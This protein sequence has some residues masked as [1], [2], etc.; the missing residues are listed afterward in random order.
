VSSLIVEET[1][2]EPLTVEVRGHQ[3]TAMIEVRGR[4][5]AG[6]VSS[7]AEALAD[8]EPQA[9]VHHIV[10]DLRGVTLIDRPG[11]RELQRLLKL[12]RD[13]DLVVLTDDPDGM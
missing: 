9:D 12:P 8:V 13:Q 3:R 4:L 5:D 7:V 10:L 2:V 6:T 11:L 1:V